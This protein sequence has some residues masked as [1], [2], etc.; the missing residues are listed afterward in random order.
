MDLSMRAARF[1][2]SERS[3]YRVVKRHATA[4]RPQDAQQIRKRQGRSALR[5][6][7]QYEN[8]QLRKTISGLETLASV[9]VPTLRELDQSICSS[10]HEHPLGYT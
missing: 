4:A 9:P 6:S 2:K 8:D 5:R 1:C 7:L 3:A 10:M